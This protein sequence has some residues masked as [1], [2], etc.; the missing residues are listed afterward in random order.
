MEAA[1]AGVN[2]AAICIYL[3]RSQQESVAYCLCEQ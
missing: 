1:D 3:T 2:E